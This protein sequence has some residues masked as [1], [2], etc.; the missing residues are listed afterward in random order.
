MSVTIR[1]DNISGVF[2]CDYH[3]ALPN[4]GRG[5]IYSLTRLFRLIYP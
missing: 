1:V 3:K 2:W 5:I 4:S